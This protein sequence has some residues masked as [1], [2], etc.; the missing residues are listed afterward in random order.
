MLKVTEKAGYEANLLLSGSVY[1]S[2]NHNEDAFE[3][4]TQ[5]F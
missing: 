3:T 5:V 1:G 2:F 4:K